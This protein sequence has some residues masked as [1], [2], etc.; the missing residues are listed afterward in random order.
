MPPWATTTLAMP[1]QWQPQAPPWPYPTDMWLENVIF[2]VLLGSSAVPDVTRLSTPI[3][4]QA[5]QH[6]LHMHVDETDAEKMEGC[7]RFHMTDR[8]LLIPTV[9]Q[10]G[11]NIMDCRSRSGRRC[12]RR[13]RMRW[14]WRWTR[15]RRISDAMRV[16]GLVLSVQP[17]GDQIA[18]LHTALCNVSLTPTQRANISALLSQALMDR[19]EAHDG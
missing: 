6:A 16:M 8:P 5:R 11:V 12:S 3:E 10:K 19:Y 2:P 18:T 17:L 9:V 1:G 15:R 7:P 4:I 14:R 13:R